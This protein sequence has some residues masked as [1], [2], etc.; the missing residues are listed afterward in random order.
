MLHLSLI[1]WP[2][3]RSSNSAPSLNV[4]VVF[5]FFL[6]VF[7]AFYVIF[8]NEPISKMGTCVYLKGWGG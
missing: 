1:A 7:H 8:Q 5:Q 2:P 4:F 3:D 6:L